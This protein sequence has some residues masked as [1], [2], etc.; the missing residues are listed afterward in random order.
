MDKVAAK[1]R[2][3]KLR[4]EIDHHRYLYHVLDKAEISDA[5]LDSLKHELARLEGDFPDLIT[6]DSPTQRVGGRPLAK[7]EKVRHP[8]PMNSLNDVFSEGEVGE[9]AHRIEKLLGYG[10]SEYYADLKMDGLAI[11]LTYRNGSLTRA[12]TRGDGQIGEDVTENIRTIEAIP[13]RLQGKPPT[14]LVVRGEV[15]FTKKEF[16][17]INAA[18]KKK[19]EKLYANPRNVAA[20][21]VRQL[22]PAITAARSLDFYAYGFVGRGEDHFNEYPS[23]DAEYKALRSYGIK[24]NPYGAVMKSVEDIV[25]FHKKW[26]TGREKLP[27]EI[28]GIVISVNDTRAYQRLGV[29]GKAPRA[30]IAYKF[31]AHEATTVLLDIIVQVGRTGT[32]TPVAVLQPVPIG[33]VTVSRATLHNQDEIE[34][35]G[36]KIGDTVIVERAGDVIPAVTGILRRLRPKHA[37]SFHMP[38]RCPMCG[39]SVVKKEGEVAYR[40]SNPHCEG[41]SRLT[42]R[43][44]VSRRAFDIRGLGGK[45]IDVLVDHG[46]IQDAADLFSLR[47]SDIEILE[48]FGKK[49][50]KN[51]IYAIQSR[52]KIELS[53]FVYALGI[54]HVGEETAVDLAKYFRTLET[55]MDASEETLRAIPDIGAVVAKSIYEWFQ[56]S[57]HRALLK[58]L[59]AAGVTPI[60]ESASKRPQKFSGKT[61]VL[62]GTLESMARDE[63]KDRIRELGGNVAGSVS[64]QTDYL[65]AGENPGSKLNR[66][67]TLGVKTIDEK[68]FLAMIR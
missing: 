1:A 37:R 33:G 61:F 13:L 43:H 66:A 57:S 48:R 20:G 32:L 5:A 17:R 59:H 67:K 25:A 27:Y 19:G 23:H 28:D 18:Q 65:V 46:L 26:I 7:F 51:L 2:I 41:R 36:V 39:S 22:D 58:K 52:K 35:L 4:S 14:E 62:T 42:I 64:A 45:I 8:V 44:F 21:S 63:A 50:A 53:R 60:S 16:L 6:R 10:V 3:Q 11:E 34:R 56:N 31:P 38:K 9:W 15:F 47:E 55:I 54:S 12:A 24:T 40:C 68:Q 49:S 29:A 30:A